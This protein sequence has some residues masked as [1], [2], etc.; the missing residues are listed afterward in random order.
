MAEAMP[1]FSLRF[2]GSIALVASVSA[3]N[4]SSASSASSASGSG[5]SRAND[6]T[7][8]PAGCPD[9]AFQDPKAG[10]C[11][12]LPKGFAKDKQEDVSSGT[13]YEFKGPDFGYFSVIVYKDATKL[14]SEKDSVDDAKKHPSD[15]TDVI[16]DT[17]TPP[18]GDGGYR[19]IN[20]RGGP[21]S[22]LDYVVLSG[23]RLLKCY[24][25]TSKNKIDAMIETC[26]TLRGLS[27]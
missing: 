11:V 4:G 2:L 7:A 22:Q 13:R 23:G 6:T 8:A 21:T 15:P 12:V 9:G 14:Q 1:Q 19:T 25:N 27:G 10:F 26:K 5:S 16:S 18:Q 3:C 17:Q 24:S 20:F